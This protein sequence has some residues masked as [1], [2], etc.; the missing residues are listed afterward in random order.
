M[1]WRYGIAA[2]LIAL[3]LL[4]TGTLWT[5][6]SN[7]MWTSTPTCENP[8]LSGRRVTVTLTDMG[9]S[10]MGAPRMWVVS[11]QPTITAGTVTFVAVNTGGFT[12]ELVVLPLSGGET[13]GARSPRADGTVDESTSVGEASKTCSAGAGNGIASGALG[14]VTLRLAPGH[15]EL[16]CNEPGH[17]RAGMHTQ[18]V[19]TSGGT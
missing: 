4:V 1:R 11:D 14:W 6:R 7:Q 8:V 3:G 17:Y 19:V 13:A 16:I 12:H 18:L 10:M 9:G 5:A 2:G 15:Y